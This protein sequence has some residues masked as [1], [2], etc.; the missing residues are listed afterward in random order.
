M[1]LKAI[2]N[3][4][5]KVKR[6]LGFKWI[7]RKKGQSWWAHFA[8]NYKENYDNYK[9]FGSVVIAKMLFIVGQA[10]LIGYS[11]I[12][13]L[14]GIG[15][16]LGGVVRLILTLVFGWVFFSIIRE[17]FL[18]KPIR[19]DRMLFGRSRRDRYG[20]GM[21]LYSVVAVVIILL[22]I[23]SVGLVVL[24]ARAYDHVHSS[25]DHTLNI[26]WGILSQF[27]DPGNLPQAVG[28]GKLVAF[29]SALAGILCLSGFV[30]T[31]MVSM[32]TRRTQY[33]QRGMIHYERDFKDYVVIIGL[34]EQTATIVKK[35]LKRKDVK[36]VLVQ[37][38][39]SVEEQRARLELKLDRKDEERVVFYFGERT[40][41]EDICDLRLENAREVYILG[42]DMDC[43]N[44]QD[45]DS[46]NM[47]CLELV[48]QYCQ[49]LSSDKSVE[50]N[51]WGEK[52]KCHVELGY[53]STYTIFKATHI[54]KQLN[55]NLEFIPFN[56]YEIWA[57]KVLVDN[58]AI[59]PGKKNDESQV[60]R[61]QP[62]DSYRDHDTYEIKGIT[63]N[64]EKSVHLIIVGMNQMG[65]ALA[66]QAAL[67]VHLPNYYS[68]G[69]RTTITF[70]DEHATQEGEYLKGHYEALFALCRQ[71]T[72]VCDC[73]TSIK[74]MNEDDDVIDPIADE[75]SRYHHLGENF[76]DIQWEFI[77]GNM[78]APC[79]RDYLIR[80]TKDDKQTCTIAVCQNDPQQSIATALY[81]PEMVLKRVQQVLVYQ[82]NNFDLI[83]KVATGEKQWKRYEKLKP[84]GMIADCYKG[85]MF[86]SIMP[87]L[88]LALYRDSTH[89]IS[90]I[91]NPKIDAYIE[92]INHMW[93]EEGIVNKL[94][95]INVTDCFKSKL[96]SVGLTEFSSKH[97]RNQV[98][99]NDELMAALDAAEHQRWVTERLTM[100]FRPLEA[101]E[102][103]YF[104]EL[105]ENNPGKPMSVEG[106]AQK[107]YHKGKSR[108]HLD[109]CSCLKLDEID[110]GTT[111]ND[112]RIIEN[113]MN[114]A[115]FVMESRIISR[116]A[117]REEPGH[118]KGEHLALAKTFLDEMVVL[119]GNSSSSVKE[120]ERMEIPRMW[121]GKYPVTQ[122]MWKKIMGQDRNPSIS[123]SEATE[124]HPVNMVSK[125]DVD[126]FL[127]I[128][129][130]KTG[131]RFS[132]PTKQEW[133]YAAL[134]GMNAIKK[135]KTIND[136]SWNSVSCAQERKNRD[137][138]IGQDSE[139]RTHQVGLKKENGYGLFDVLGNV[140]EWTRTMSEASTY[141]FCGGSW[142]YGPKECELSDSGESWCK[143]WTPEHKSDDLGLR[144]VLYHDFPKCKSLISDLMI[145]K[146]KMISNIATHMVPVDAGNFFMGTDAYEVNDGVMNKSAYIKTLPD[147]RPAHRVKMSAFL[148][149]SIPVTQ[150]QYT[151]IMDNNPSEQKGFNL[152]IENVSYLDAMEFVKS[153]NA[154]CC[155]LLPKEVVPQD[156]IIFALP[157]QAQ[158]EYAARGGCKSSGDT[159]YSGSDNPDVVAWHFGNI[160]STHVVRAKS[161]NALGIHDMCG[162]VWEWCSDLYQSDY[163]EQCKKGGLVA[164]P[165]GPETGITHVLRGGSWRFTA[166]ECRLTRLSHWPEDYKAAD[167]GFRL[168]A[169]V[170]KSVIDKLKEG[171]KPK[172]KDT[173]SAD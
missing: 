48:S 47:K 115:F 41:Y 94:S 13:W 121:V 113:L 168:V 171:V 87:K 45:H 42:E 54:Y 75:T 110:P 50:K 73:N 169:N 82:R 61:Y 173:G 101:K 163:Y 100:G 14:D 20:W 133:R 78:A 165:K 65:I 17:V 22:F 108:A 159:V 11:L 151:A 132:L 104:E 92:H 145:E 56:V 5:P 153:L 146:K 149:S 136:S 32:I 74:S 166:G 76:M 3:F 67:L 117:L 156:G 59:L 46:N 140:W 66:M 81:L 130:D 12:P 105:A 27:A 83:N 53:Q 63:I 162:N 70:I 128:L 119:N 99:S 138:S 107:E 160:K 37:T 127:L 122:K 64:S 4:I 19:R 71:R 143:S 55:Q 170:D 35:S 15:T 10:W 135:R 28:W 167:V 21:G 116:L 52:L 8:E 95:N 137:T 102:M 125:E 80:E 144:L 111:V 164:D 2:K 49:D 158:W 120:P 25:G 9:F 142:R 91:T 38:C 123:A 84:F 6:W 16:W 96:R 139:P 26:I 30:I 58:Y 44:E 62:I 36:Y 79:I 126:D 24:Q 29:M 109:I 124:L 77:E 43:E 31:S 112:H 60:Q 88:V 106:K 23:C 129:N 33:W 155:A 7:K 90:N 69:I 118:E 161:G 34:N 18:Y 148:I 85:D 39:R 57:K 98:L 114:L 51:W 131:L 150:R 172:D 152:P 97:E 72:I 103:A 1:K 147:E 68:K 157:T 154:E 89:S 40:H 93:S 141:C 134:G 86:D